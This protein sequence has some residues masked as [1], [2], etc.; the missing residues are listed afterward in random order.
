MSVAGREWTRIDMYYLSPLVT[1]KS[2]YQA[3]VL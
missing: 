1:F 3:P 2:P